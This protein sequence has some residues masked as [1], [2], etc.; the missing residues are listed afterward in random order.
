MD[1]ILFCLNILNINKEKHYILLM[2]RYIMKVEA[3]GKYL[4][5]KG[6]A[7]WLRNMKANKYKKGEG[8]LK[9]SKDFFLK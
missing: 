6:E 9:E 3:E 2:K 4:Y 1:L 7:A 5:L 8:F